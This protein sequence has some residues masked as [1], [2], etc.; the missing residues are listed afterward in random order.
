MATDMMLKLTDIEGESKK[1]GVE[2]QIDVSDFSFGVRQSA[3]SH[4]GGGGGAGRA[5]VQDMTI[6][7]FVDKSS[8]VLFLYSATGKPIA[9]AVLT[10]RKVGG[11]SLD[12]LVVT[13]TDVIVSNVSSGGASSDDRVRETVSLNFAKIAIKYTAQTKDGAADAT[14]EKAF[15][16]EANAEA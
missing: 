11:T 4:E 2:K 1:T 7:K 14:V 9:E 8:P 12:Y 3:T 6:T 13:M 15:D 10:V 16:V 5:D